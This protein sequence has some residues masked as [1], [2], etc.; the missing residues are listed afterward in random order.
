[1]TMRFQEALIGWEPGTD[2]VRVDTVRAN[3][4]DWIDHYFCCGGAVELRV[5]ELKDHSSELRATIFEQFHRLVV[6][7]GVDPHAVHREF[8][9]IDQY[10]ERLQFGA[11]TRFW[12]P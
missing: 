1:M 9:K 7:D 11:G 10:R 2:K 8:L 4:P 12:E 5:R 3:E 6:S